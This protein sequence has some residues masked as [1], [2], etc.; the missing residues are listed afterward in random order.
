MEE[1]TPQTRPSDPHRRHVFI[2]KLLQ[3]PMRL[4]GWLKFGFIPT[5]ERVEG[6]FLLV[7]NH[8]TN[9][10]PILVS[11][12]FPE[13]QMYFVASEHIFRSPIAGRLVAWAQDPI[14]RQKG[15]SAANT[16]KAMLRRLKAGYNVAVFPEGNRSW[17]GVTG[18][19]P[20]S[21]GKLA[22]TCGATLVTYRLS[23]GYFASPRWSGNSSRRGKMRGRVTGVYTPEQLRAM[24]V[25]QIN[26]RIREGISED[27]YEDARKAPVRWRGRKLAEHLETLLYLCPACGRFHTL[28]SRDDT[29]RCRCGLSARYLPTGFLAGEGL[30]FDNLRDW[31]RW[32]NR[33]LRRRCAE[34]GE[35]PIL[36][37]TEITADEVAFARGQKRLGKGEMKLFADRLELPGVSVALSEISGMS[38]MGPQRLFVGAG[39]RSFELRSNQPRCMIKYI[40]ACAALTGR[41]DLGV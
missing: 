19:F 40:T 30:P 11:S 5:I 24:S 35:K 36:S 16:V 27:A 26:E 21:I 37:D 28:V 7:S 15:G 18:R 4:I 39:G 13:G 25:E 33:E 3:W 9:W 12:S 14:P 41:E 8:N 32:Q 6:P 20:S 22:K 10:D 34:P 1:K 29:L 23:G 31:N 38:V 17:D 2:W